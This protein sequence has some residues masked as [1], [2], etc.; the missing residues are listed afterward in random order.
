MTDIIPQ[1]KIAI[2]K[3]MYREIKNGKKLKFIHIPKC[4]GSYASQYIE[5]FKIIN[6]GHKVANEYDEITIGIIRNPIQ[7]FES[8]LNFRLSKDTP[9]RDWPKRLH[10]LHYDKTKSLNDIIEKLSP[11]EI[12]SFDPFKTYLYWTQNIKLLV[13]INEFLPAL[14]LLG[15]STDKKFPKMNVS[16]KNRGTL[17][18]ESIHKLKKI[19]KIDMKIYNFWT[20]KCK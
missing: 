11:Y 6:N 15:Y 16:D 19:L 13:T 12:L 1:W 7:R 8:F 9:G 20:R 2:I 5:Y 18:E 17:S 3:K 4:A 10:Y 14:H